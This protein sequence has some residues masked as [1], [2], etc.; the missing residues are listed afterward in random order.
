MGPYR[1]ATR[2]EGRYAAPDR[3]DAYLELEVHQ[4]NAEFV[5]VGFE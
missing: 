4:V 1:L 2:G 5:P 3:A